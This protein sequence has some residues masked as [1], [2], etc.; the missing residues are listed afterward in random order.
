MAQ[1]ITRQIK[2]GH[3]VPVFNSITGQTDFYKR[4]RNSGLFG[5]TRNPYNI[6]SEVTG[7]S[8]YTEDQIAKKKKQ[9]L[10]D[11]MELL[12]KHQSTKSDNPE[13]KKPGF[14][15][16]L[17]GDKKKDSESTTSFPEAETN[18]FPSLSQK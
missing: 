11:Y 4:I 15:K 14:L 3:L 16:R 17:F 12:S 13:G 10:K 18:T 8:H 9:G 2:R 5:I 6:N 1:S 7:S